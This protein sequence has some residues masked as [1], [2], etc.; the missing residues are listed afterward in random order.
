[1]QDLV[2]RNVCQEPAQDYQFHYGGPSYLF[3]MILLKCP[4][5]RVAE[6]TVTRDGLSAITE[7]NYPGPWELRT[8]DCHST[9]GKQLSYGK[10]GVGELQAGPGIMVRDRRIET[11]RYGLMV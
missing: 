10:L 8:E 4:D 7:S 11:E 9:R 2:S 1:M 6:S 3:V 5:S